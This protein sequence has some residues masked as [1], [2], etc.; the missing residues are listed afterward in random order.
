MYDMKLQ[1]L[2]TLKCTTM[3]VVIFWNLL[4]SLCVISFSPLAI[5]NM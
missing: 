3:Y 1:P 5:V 2:N 4:Y